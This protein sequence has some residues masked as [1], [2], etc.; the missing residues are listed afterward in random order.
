M[1]K[2]SFFIDLNIKNMK[3]KEFKIT[4]FK[5]INNIVVNLDKSPSANVY[6][7]IGL[8]ES[9]KT[10]ILEAINFFDQ[11]NHLQQLYQ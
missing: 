6:T 10:S 9:G 8:N 11:N 3:F 5:G 2:R 1:F 4:N 7:L